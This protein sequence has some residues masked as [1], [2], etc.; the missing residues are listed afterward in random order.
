MASE[1]D[2]KQAGSKPQ[3]N[4]DDKAKR[5]EL[6]EAR[7]RMMRK[8]NEELMKRQQEIEEDRRNANRYSEMV[9]IDRKSVV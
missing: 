9:V 2:H 6:V 4:A 1:I 5:E 7:I 3:D 8:K